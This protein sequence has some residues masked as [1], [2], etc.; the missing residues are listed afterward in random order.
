M[1]KNLTILKD[2]R[3]YI[4]NTVYRVCGVLLYMLKVLCKKKS[5]AKSAKSVVAEFSSKLPATCL[6]ITCWS[7]CGFTNQKKGKKNKGR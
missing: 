5:L 7:E 3:F 2:N 4:S 6:Q 1:K